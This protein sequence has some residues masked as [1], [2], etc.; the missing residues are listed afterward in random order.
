M[1]K[2]NQKKRLKIVITST[3]IG[4]A[5]FNLLIWIIYFYIHKTLDNEIGKSLLKIGEISLVK[6]DPKVL[7]NGKKT[8][9]EI[10]IIKKYLNEIKNKGIIENVY[11]IDKNNNIVMDPNDEI[12][13][14]IFH[15]YIKRDKKELEAA[16]FGKPS[17][18]EIYSIK[19][20]YFK[21]AYLPIIN[22]S[23]TVTYVLCVEASADTLKTIEQLKS[24][25]III[26]LSSIILALIFAYY[27]GKTIKDFVKIE[28]EL[29]A[30]E[31]FALM[32]Q[33]SANVAHEIRNPLSIIKGAGDILKKR[34]KE[35]EFVQFINEEI[36]R[37][38][39]LINEFLTLSKDI[40]LNKQKIDINTLISSIIQNITIN[41]AKL[42]N[43]EKIKLDKHLD[44]KIPEIDA[45]PEKLKQVLLNIILNAV[46]S[47]ENTGKITITTLIEKKNIKIIIA[48]TGAGIQEENIEKIFLPF[49]T[50]KKS[51]VGVGL[52]IAQKIVQAHG[53]YIDVQSK[54]G[55]GSEFTIVIPYMDKNRR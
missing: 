36:D 18:T 47:I 41:E 43:A 42:I 27:L 52:S 13:E 54:F 33:I 29:Q 48:D 15:S 10:K 1:I 40:T 45:D 8:D 22:D 19:G 23:G 17:F 24:V 2:Q 25:L 16:W 46:D 5:I 11:I 49:F 37:I 14:N 21:N 3:L 32:G 30:R 9:I 53:G 12:I 34:Y 55:E 31:K 50:T 28:Q 35:E 38:N 4:L 20:Y 51:G 6:I 39:H 7:D 26:S 44:K